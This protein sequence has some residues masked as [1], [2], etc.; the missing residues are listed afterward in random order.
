VDSVRSLCLERRAL[1]WRRALT[2]AQDSTADWCRIRASSSGWENIGQWPV[3]IST[4]RQCSLV[5]SSATSSLGSAPSSRHLMY[6]AETIGRW[7]P[8]GV[9][10][11]GRQ[12]VSYTQV[13]GGLA[14]AR[15]PSEAAHTDAHRRRPAPPDT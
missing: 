1:K 7:R 5:S 12:G 14:L 10:A 4:S 13:N 9:P 3:F 11:P 2:V 8:A 15:A 6:V